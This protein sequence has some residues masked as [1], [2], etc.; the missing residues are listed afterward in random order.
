[1][2]VDHFHEHGGVFEFIV[3]LA[4]PLPATDC[5]CMQGRLNKSVQRYQVLEYNV[6]CIRMHMS[7]YV[8]CAYARTSIQVRF[9]TLR[10][11]V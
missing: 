10:V 7:N 5:T 3:P 2:V 1:M 11:H 8:L 9:K 4:S 6:S